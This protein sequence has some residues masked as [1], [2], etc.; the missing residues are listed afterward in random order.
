VEDVLEILA[1]PLL[2][3]VMESPDVLTASNMGAPVTLHNP[4]SPAAQAYTEAARR[5]L[6]E[7]IPVNQPAPR[8]GG[9]FSRLFGKKAAAA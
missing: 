6:G 7:E 2:G 1:V 8:Q 3:I 4:A 5:L 9:L